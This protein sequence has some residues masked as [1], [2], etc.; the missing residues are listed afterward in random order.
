MTIAQLHQ[1][2]PIPDHPIEAAESNKWELF[3]LVSGIALPTD[4]KQYLEHYG[5]GIIGSVVIPYN[6]FCL[7][8]L[9]K[10]HQTCRDWMRQL[11]GIQDL[12][13]HFGTA[14]FPYP[15]YPESG[16]ALPWGST[17]N[18]DQL[19]WLTEGE[20]DS[21]TVV[22]NEARSSEFEQF[23]KTMTTF[24]HNWIQDELQSRILPHYEID[25][26]ALFTRL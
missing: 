14:V 22:I 26:E 2:L 17:E 7:R 21:W 4:Y 15:I 13:Q 24:L 25:Q 10:V 9:P 8:S 16:G 6:P 23:D 5:T 20:P 19:F 11:L 12:K 18:G 1:V 3:E